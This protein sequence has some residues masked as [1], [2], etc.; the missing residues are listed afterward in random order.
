[1]T[2]NS[3]E[4]TPTQKIVRYGFILSIFFLAL[5]GFGQMPIF[6]R[7]YIADI[8]GLA[9]LA[10]F[11]ITLSIHYLS[12]ILLLAI[13]LYVVVDTF[14]L[15]KGAI[16]LT[17]IGYAKSA[18]IALLIVTGILLVI[19]NLAGVNLPPNF[20]IALYL[21]HLV[22]VMGFLTVSAFGA[23]FK[24]RWTTLR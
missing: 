2:T 9:W 14:L 23:I 6:K 24:K 17:P 11:Y 19:K 4:T 12:A 1:M 8:P 20:I 10:E 3:T 5:T 13:V 21:T 16:R 7:Y 22:G 18:I 15:Q